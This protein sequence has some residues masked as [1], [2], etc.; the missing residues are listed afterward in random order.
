MQSYEHGDPE[1]ADLES[2]LSRLH[3]FPIIACP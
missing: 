1:A 3:P 2:D